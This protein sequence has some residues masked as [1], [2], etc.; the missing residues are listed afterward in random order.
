MLGVV[1]VSTGLWSPSN[2]KPVAAASN[3]QFVAK[4]SQFKDI[5]FHYASEAI[6]WA[7]KKG[8]V[9]GYADGRFGPN[10]N[11][12]E[13]Q[14]AK[15][16]SEYFGLQDSG[17]KL[18]NKTGGAVWTDAYYNKLAGYGVPLNG[19]YDNGI[20]NQ[21]VKRGTVAQS[22]AYL[23]GYQMNLTESINYLLDNKITVGQNSAYEND[24]L[25]YFGSSNDL[26]R[27]QVVTFL[28]RIDGNGLS[29]LGTNASVTF[30][31]DS[32]FSLNKRANAGKNII[33]SSL[34]KGN[35]VDGSNDVI[36]LPVEPS[37]PTADPEPVVDYNGYKLPFIKNAD[38][39][40]MDKETIDYFHDRLGSANVKNLFS[41][42]GFEVVSAYTDS[43]AKSLVL[44]S[45]DGNVIV[46]SIGTV[47]DI[48]S[49]KIGDADSA[50][51]ILNYVYGYNFKESDLPSDQRVVQLN[52]KLKVQIS[53]VYKGGTFYFEKWR[54]DYIQN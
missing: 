51:G 5:N 52:Y 2:T 3:V 47:E 40:Y 21:T 46:Y 17:G 33:D 24:L 44:I 35:T 34:K 27:A 41:G 50:L 11:V 26:T 38:P 32:G 25:K 7:K 53:E 54:D 45:K 43:L 37:I 8:I 10:D 28:Y 6:H 18:M 39:R 31:N 4:Q 29:K 12:T 13:G 1:I 42:K 36:K 9:D 22:L 20:R 19:Y 15:M 48:L 30:S 49:Y 14:F 23:S 16:I